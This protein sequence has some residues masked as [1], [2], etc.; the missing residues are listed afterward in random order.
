MSTR[1]VWTV[2]VATG[3]AFATASALA[4]GPTPLHGQKH[5]GPGPVAQHLDVTGRVAQLDAR[6]AMLEADMRMLAGEM[7]IQVMSDLIEALI[8]R[9]YLMERTVRPMH[10]I[11]EEWMPHATRPAA[12]DA[13]PDSE[14]MAPEGM[15]LP[16]S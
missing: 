1:T 16:H 15:C 13:V 6:M 8:E 2:A 7:K 4:Q 12:P 14:E 9:Q 3:V 5:R 11:M 10:E